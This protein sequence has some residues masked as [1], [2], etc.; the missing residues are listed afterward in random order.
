MRAGLALVGRDASG[1]VV[2]KVRF[3][4]NG[5]HGSV[6]LASPGNFDRI[7]A[8]VVNGDYRVSGFDQIHRDWNYTRDSAKITAR[9][10]R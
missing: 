3:L 6:T 5:G 4:K 1:R 8:V 2:T 10:S 7:T 9:L